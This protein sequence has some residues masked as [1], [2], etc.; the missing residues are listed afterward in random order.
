[1]PTQSRLA[2]IELGLNTTLGTSLGIDFSYYDWLTDPS[3]GAVGCVQLVTTENIFP[4]TY[5]RSEYEV[6]ASIQVASSISRAEFRYLLLDWGSALAAAMQGLRKTGI[7]GTYRGYTFN[8]EG[9]DVNQVSPQIFEL[10][11]KQN[12]QDLPDDLSIGRVSCNYK[13]VVAGTKLDAML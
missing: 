5:Q 2:A 10:I 11:T 6:L 8:G 3:R 7:I 9:R 12:R 1:M 13:I 4:L